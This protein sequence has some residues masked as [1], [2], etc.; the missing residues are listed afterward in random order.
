LIVD[1]TVGVCVRTRSVPAVTVTTSEMVPTSSLVVMLFVDRF[2]RTSISAVLKPVVI[3]TGMRP[4]P[5]LNEY[6]PLALVTPLSF[7]RSPGS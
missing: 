7:R 4:P 1:V 3:V 2:T 5:S 6:P